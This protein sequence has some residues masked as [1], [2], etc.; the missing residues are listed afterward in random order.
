MSDSREFF[1]KFRAII[2]LLAVF[3]LFLIREAFPWKNEP[4]KKILENGLTLIYQLDKSSALTILQICIKGGK[5]AEPLEK[6]GLAH[7]A[8]RLALEI[9]DVGKAQDLMSQS[10]IVYMMSR[11]DYSQININCLSENLENTLKIVSEIM[12]NPLLSGI[13]ID[14]NKE[15]M[16]DQRKEE[17][18]DLFKAGHNAFLEKIFKGSSYGGSVLGNEES[19][20]AIKKKDIEDF[21]QSYFKGGNMI[22][23]AISDL[24][25]EPLFEVLNKYLA[26]FPPGKAPES[27]LSLLSIPE[28]K[29]IAIEK[30][31]KQFMICEA[32]PLPKVTAKNYTLA[33][34]FENLLG[35]GVNS[36]LWPLRAKENLAY[37]VNC[38]ATQ[39]RDGGTLEAYLETGKE[40]KEIALEALKKILDDL[41]EKGI[42]EEELKVT[43][44]NL[45]SSFLRNNE[46]KEA[47]ASTLSFFE[48]QGLGLEFFNSFFPEI[49]AVSLEEI[50]AYIKEVLNPEKRIE[51]I[52]GPK[53]EV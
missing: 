24:E 2:L 39:M 48:A 29:K 28:E 47:R 9:P 21:S 52:V 27:K 22:A 23:V 46:T 5:G 1:S 19:L 43:K 3:S 37:D 49:D 4:E 41:F 36:K 13:R 30:D 18:D 40:K 17:E 11:G 25:K 7:L 53:S 45:K 31:T 20:K 10:S 35:K 15:R 16:L 51:V 8:T 32:S 44:I 6:G 33:C 12:L 38:V 14:R 50:N 34:L 26:Q 42:A